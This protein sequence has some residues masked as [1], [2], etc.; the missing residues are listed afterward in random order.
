MRNTWYIITTVKEE[1]QAKQKSF[2]V[3]QIVQTKQ[4]GKTNQGK[5]KKQT[6]EKQQKYFWSFC[7]LRKQKQRRTKT[8]K[9]MK[10]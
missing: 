9:R 10:T 1:K 6:K 5:K 4:K 7:V 8:K 2:W 3:F